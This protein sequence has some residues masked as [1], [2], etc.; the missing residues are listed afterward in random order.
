MELSMNLTDAQK[1]SRFVRSLILLS[2]TCMIIVTI[3]MIIKLRQPLK[4]EISFTVIQQGDKRLL[5]AFSTKTGEKL[6]DITLASP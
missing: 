3:A 2:M 1:I 4:A 6:G 5:R